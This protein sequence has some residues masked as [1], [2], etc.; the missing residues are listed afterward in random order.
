MQPN[1]DNLQY[2][3]FGVMTGVAGNAIWMA[4]VELVLK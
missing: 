1:Q 2:W 4:F 3:L